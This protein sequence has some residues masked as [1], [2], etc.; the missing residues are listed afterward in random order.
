MSTYQEL[1]G[2]KIKYLSA[3]TS[4]DRLQEG[5]LFYNSS[6]FNLKAFAA[7]AAWHSGGSLLTARAQVGGAGTQ[8]AGLA[9][10]GYPGG[11]ATGITEEY[12]GTGWSESGDLNTARRELAGLGIQTAALAVGGFISPSPDANLQRDET[13]NYNGTSWSE[14]NDLTTAKRTHGSAGTTSAGLVFG[15]LTSPHPTYTNQTEEWDGTNWSEQNNLNTTRSHLSGA[16]TQT[17]ALGFGGYIGGSGGTGATEEYDGSSWT[18]VNSMNTARRTIGPAGTQTAALGFGGSAVPSSPTTSNATEQ[19]DGT[20]WTTSPATLSLGRRDLGGCGTQSTALAFAGNGPS[21][22]VSSTEEFTVSLTATTAAAFSA[23]GDNNDYQFGRN[24][25][26]GGT[27]SATYINGGYTYVSLTEEYNGSS[28]SEDGDSSNGR[29]FGTGAG[30]LTAG[31]AF[32]GYLPGTGATNVTEEYNG[33]SWSG[34]GNMNVTT[35]SRMGGGTQTA[36]IGAGGTGPITATEYYNGSSWSTQ[37]ATLNETHRERNGVGTQSSY[38]AM[39]GT[40]PGETVFY[41]DVEE[42]NG[43]TWTSVTDMVTASKNAAGIIG[44]SAAGAIYCGGQN[45]NPGTNVDDSQVF[46]GTTVS[47]GVSPAFSARSGNQGA[48]TTSAGLISARYSPANSKTEH[49]TGETTA[50]RAVKTIDFD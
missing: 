22:N 46:N 47:S 45:D 10:G 38:V 18:S 28:W 5:E 24:W 48:G 49:F 20:T 40:N 30:T 12:N 34:G 26:S 41:T 6:D 29:Y 44:N 50:A 2:L 8:T 17:A 14:V 36:T 21:P 13:E 43:S 4:G 16:G 31:I 37:P 27:S 9:F 32:G 15:G 3:D 42:Y 35:G 7:T 1:K 23:G 25:A 19:Y 33:S 11:S 39:G